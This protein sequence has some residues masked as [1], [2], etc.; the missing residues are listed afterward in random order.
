[1]AR[2]ARRKDGSV[3]VFGEHGGIINNLPSPVK[4]P[5]PK[6]EVLPR[7][8]HEPTTTPGGPDHEIVF[9]SDIVVLANRVA[10]LHGDALDVHQIENLLYF[11]GKTQSWKDNSYIPEVSEN[12][13]NR[14]LQGH[15][16][17]LENP[18][19]RQTFNRVD[20]EEAYAAIA[21]LKG[22]YSSLSPQERY[23]LV[24][25]SKKM[26]H[27]RFAIEREYVS[28]AL[29]QNP[30]PTD[31]EMKA[32]VNYHRGVYYSLDHKD[33]PIVPANYYNGFA[34]SSFGIPKDNGTI[35]GFYKAETTRFSEGT[36]SAGTHF[37]AL[38]TETSGL[39]PQEG[40]EIV[41]I[42]YAIYDDQ[43]VMLDKQSTFVKP[44]RTHP[45]G[46]PDTGSP[47][48]VSVH[49]IT[50]D[51]VVNARRFP[52]VWESI[53]QQMQGGVIVGHNI[54]FDLKQLRYQFDAH[55][56][57]VSESSVWW[58]RADTLNYARRHI[59]EVKSKRL[60]T[61]TELFNIPLKNAHQAG[62]DA[63]AAGDLF[64]KL[65]NHRP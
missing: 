61:L 47:K 50:P 10:D 41:E 9:D 5:S 3:A 52:E 32:L 43:G 46:S 58:G 34:R 56:L 23:N 45:D 59:T 63:A 27:A 60:G 55:N 44:E 15:L 54:E 42:G 12:E 62:D 65:R 64:F 2:T 25:L 36:F 28:I 35:Y 37:V 21:R 7:L 53:S 16:L 13:W 51:R 8:F 26:K 20:D 48:A 14:Y 39:K 49:N 18:V 1:M 24:T 19:S 29:F 40:A 38:D 22:K 11:G 30:S 17:A 33:R 6:P 31:E 4:P 57:G